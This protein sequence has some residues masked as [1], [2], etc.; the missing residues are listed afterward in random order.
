M[1]HEECI[2]CKVLAGE[3]PAQIVDGRQHF[4]FKRYSRS[5]EGVFRTNAENGRVEVLETIC[6]NASGNLGAP[7]QCQ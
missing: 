4:V 1:A 6:C 2:F 7:A 5:D 3:I